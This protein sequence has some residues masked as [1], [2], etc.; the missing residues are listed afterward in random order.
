MTSSH[1]VPWQPEYV[2]DVSDAA[3]ATRTYL[4]H[5][6]VRSLLRQAAGDH[7]F[8][9]ACEV[10]AGYGRMTVVLTEFADRVIGLER[11]ARFVEE[12]RRLLP[13]IEFVQVESLGTLPVQT[14]SVDC[15][16][17]FTVLQHLIDAV[18]QAV[19]LE[20]ARIVKPG[21]YVLMCEE[22]DSAHRN[23]AVDDPNGICTIGRPVEAYQR[24]LGT[25]DLVATKPRRIEPTYPRSDVGTYMLFRR[26]AGVQP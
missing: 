6:D 20:I 16:L 17:T 11:E 7:R 12:A 4:E 3:F 9:T 19:A 15:L 13:A 1:H 22:T 10:G 25:C 14:A 8:G 21:G 24:L 18:A 23:G 26:Q 2:V 5:A